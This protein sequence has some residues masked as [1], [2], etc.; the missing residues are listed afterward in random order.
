MQ[1][2]IAKVVEE[3]RREDDGGGGG[4]GARVSYGRKGKAGG[5]DGAEWPVIAKDSYDAFVRT[6][7]EEQL[8][9][10]GVRRV[11]LCG[12]L[13]DCCVDTTAKGTFNR[14][15]ETLIAREA[16]GA[17]GEREGKESLRVFER[18]YGDVVGVD[19]VLELVKGEGQELRV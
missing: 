15:F 6:T 14:G 19:E 1:P 17:A 5:W 7:L 4:G 10:R 8:R 12:T 13:T 3:T 16:C 11:V 2:E 18:Y 9:E